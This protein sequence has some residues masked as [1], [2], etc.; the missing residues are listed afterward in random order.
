[1]RCAIG[2]RTAE[3]L[4]FEERLAKAGADVKVATDDGSRGHKGF[5][6]QLAEAMVGER[7]PDLIIACG[8]EPMLNAVVG[9][10]TK[11]K[12]E[13]QCSLE[14]YMKCGIGLCGSC[15]CGKYT[16]CGDGPVFT[17]QQLAQTEDF[18][19]WKRDASGRRIGL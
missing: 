3:E 15:Q 16:V 6:T 19:K 7:M 13:C 8:P 1:V 17:A 2:A 18:G 4:L 14:R 10:A 12:I 11:Y 5:V 9:M